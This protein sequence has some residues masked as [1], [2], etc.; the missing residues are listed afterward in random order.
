L[1]AK[2]KRSRERRIEERGEERAVDEC[3]RS[4][5]VDVDIGAGCDRLELS[6]NAG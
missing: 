3:G 1:P 4:V 5:T 2:R 6:V